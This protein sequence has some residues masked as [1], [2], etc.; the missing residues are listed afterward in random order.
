M[1]DTPMTAPPGDNTGIIDQMRA[2]MSDMEARTAQRIQQSNHQLQK[3]LTEALKR[4][5]KQG[6]SLQKIIDAQGAEL[7]NVMNTIGAHAHELQATRAEIER[8]SASAASS[9]RHTP[10]DSDTEEGRQMLGA[11]GVTVTRPVARKMLDFPAKFGGKTADFRSWRAAM[12]HKLSMDSDYIGEPQQHFYA[13]YTHLEGTA[14]DVV[15]VYYEEAVRTNTWDVEGFWR[16]LENNFG[17]PGREAR[18]ARTLQSLRMRPTE[19]FAKFSTKFEKALVEAGGMTYPD[20]V[21]IMLLDA[22]LSQPLRYAMIPITDMPVE[23][24]EWHRKVL[25]IATR[26]EAANQAHQWNNQQRTQQWPPATNHQTE[27]QQQRC[28]AD[29]DIQMVGANAVKMKQDNN[30]PRAPWISMEERER[31][32][33]E[34][35][36]MRCGKANHRQKTCRLRPALRPS[37]VRVA[38]VQGSEEQEGAEGATNESGN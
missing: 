14:K 16:Y 3:Q 6:A 38:M 24:P 7:H 18:A 8:I 23:Y 11:P 35:L 2:L 20:R 9:R 26:L 1:D 25:D 30:A 32:R 4:T 29:G 10:F 19:E 33:E 36:C 31:R 37:N 13:I 17:D 34:G 15:N 5:E 27:A 28:D 22:A 12:K 21:K